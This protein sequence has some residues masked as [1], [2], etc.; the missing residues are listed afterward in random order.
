[1]GDRGGR[2]VCVVGVVAAARRKSPTATADDI[3][4]TLVKR[5]DLEMKVFVTGELRAKPFGDL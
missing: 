4:T 1:M 2:S 5:G 3:P